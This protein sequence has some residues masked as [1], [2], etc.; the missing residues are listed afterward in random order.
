[1]PVGPTNH[2]SVNASRDAASQ[3]ATDHLRLIGRNDVA[4]S[5]E[6]EAKRH[7]PA[8][9]A[10]VRSCWSTGTGIA[11]R[12]GV[13]FLIASICVN[14][15]VASAWQS[16]FSA[17][18][19]SLASSP[20]S[21]DAETRP[22][23]LAQAMTSSTPSETDRSTRESAAPI[24]LSIPQP[25][26]EKSKSRGFQLPQGAGVQTVVALSV[27][28]LLFLG[29]A[30][31]T[32][33]AQPR[34]MSALPREAVELLGRIPIDTKQYLQLVRFGRKLVLINV[35]A[36]GVTSVSEVEDPAEVE[37]LLGM[38]RSRQSGSSADSFRESLRLDEQ[39]P[40][41]GGFLGAAER[42][43]VGN[44]GSGSKGRRMWTHA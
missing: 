24:P 18:P 17:S 36:Q 1:M 35:S 22:L 31:V 14:G 3:R 39:E 2:A 15:S 37:H 21:R 30:W 6:V 12:L 23:P 13:H 38:C 8:V 41:G 32:K 40:A 7:L 25:D 29:V 20:M 5:S 33:K 9:A 19:A 44:R 26:Q 42:R 28:L 16:Q 4:R 27:V 10:R 34:S 43:G 11:C